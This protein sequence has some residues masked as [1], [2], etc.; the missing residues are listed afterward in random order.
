MYNSRLWDLTHKKRRK[1]TK[2]VMD[3]AS[4]VSILLIL[5]GKMFQIFVTKHEVKQFR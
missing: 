4:L 3:V 5:L 1:T 2:N